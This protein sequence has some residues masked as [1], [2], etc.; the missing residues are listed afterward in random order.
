MGIKTYS[1]VYLAVRKTLREAGIESSDL[2]SRLMAAKAT[3]KTVAAGST[4]LALGFVAVLLG[5]QQQN[6]AAG[7]FDRLSDFVDDEGGFAA[8]DPADEKS[9]SAARQ[10]AVR[11][12]TAALL[13]TS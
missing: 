11:A 5:D 2:D 8:A 7:P 6:P 1:E 9:H 3:G 10:A 12:A 13:R 4:K